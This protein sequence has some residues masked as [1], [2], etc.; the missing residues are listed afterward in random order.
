M[1]NARKTLI[2]KDKNTSVPLYE[3]AYC[4]LRYP[5]KSIYLLHNIFLIHSRTPPDWQCFLLLIWRIHM[6][7]LLKFEGVY[8]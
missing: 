5:D 7:V 6:P 4:P 3:F 1:I 2:V 8:D